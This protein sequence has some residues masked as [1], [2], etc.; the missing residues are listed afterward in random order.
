MIEIFHERTFSTF[1]KLFLNVDTKLNPLLFNSD[2]IYVSKTIS[3]MSQSFN[4]KKISYVQ[5]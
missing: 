4:V 3:I 5:Q 1:T 2:H